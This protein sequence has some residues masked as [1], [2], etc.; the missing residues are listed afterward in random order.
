MAHL[1]AMLLRYLPEYEAFQCFM[2]LLHSFH[3]LSF[4]RG[5]MREVEWRVRF[6][7]DLLRERLPLVSEHLRSKLDL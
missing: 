5:D 4:F 6:F 3:F 2:N 1:A 7:D